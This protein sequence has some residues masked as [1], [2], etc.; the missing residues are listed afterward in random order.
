VILSCLRLGST[1]RTVALDIRGACIQAG[2]VRVVE[3]SGRGSSCWLHCHEDEQARR[4]DTQQS[5]CPPFTRGTLP[6]L[7]GLDR[8]YRPEQNISFW[9]CLCMVSMKFIHV[10]FKYSV[11]T[12]QETYYICITKHNRLMLFRKT[13][14]VYCENHM[15]YINTLCGQNAEFF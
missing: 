14:A 8:C 3:A 9:S 2:L 5:C 6:V 12:S 4:D 1:Y 13:V 15:K 10:T 11:H 7:H